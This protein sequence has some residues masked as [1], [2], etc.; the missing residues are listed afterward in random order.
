MGRYDWEVAILKCFESVGGEAD[1]QRVYKCIPDFVQLTKEHYKEQF[2][3]PAYHN[4]VRSHIEKLQGSGDLI[5]K[6]RGRYALTQQGLARTQE[7]PGVRQRLRAETRQQRKA[8][9][10]EGMD[11]PEDTG[12]PDKN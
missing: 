8:L 4:Q 12:L 3:V 7:S 10:A 9:S 11:F 1:L 5:Q 6:D 2:G